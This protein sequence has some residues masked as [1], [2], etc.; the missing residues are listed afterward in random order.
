MAILPSL[1]SSSNVRLVI[2][3]VMISSPNV[4]LM[5]C[6]GLSPGQPTNHFRLSFVRVPGKND[7]IWRKRLYHLQGNVI[8][9]ANT[10]LANSRNGKNC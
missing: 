7:A 5:K 3:L 9:S 1:S 6:V 2:S 4:V 10:N 8:K